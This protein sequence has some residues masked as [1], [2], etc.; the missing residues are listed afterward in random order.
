MSQPVLP[1]S[2]P[3]VQRAGS[4][5]SGGRALHPGAL[6]TLRPGS[7]LFCALQSPTASHSWHASRAQACEARTVPG[8]GVHCVDGHKCSEAGSHDVGEFI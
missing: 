6:H 4:R 7:F 1:L 3:H 5:C 8:A 2:P